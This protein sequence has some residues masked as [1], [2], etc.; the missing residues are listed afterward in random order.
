MFCTIS[1]VVEKIIVHFY[2]LNCL[3]EE[4]SKMTKLSDKW[5]SLTEDE[6]KQWKD[7]AA[8]GISS[9]TSTPETKKK[10]IRELTSITQENVSFLYAHIVLHAL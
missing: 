4:S 1:C 8:K 2:L 10:A 9:V 6:K 3:V 5:A 7:K